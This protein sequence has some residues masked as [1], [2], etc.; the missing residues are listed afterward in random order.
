M[1][2]RALVAL[3]AMLAAGCGSWQVAQSG[4]RI[5]PAPYGEEFAMRVHVN[6]LKRLGGDVK[7]TEFR[8]YVAERLQREGLCPAGW[9]RQLCAKGD[10]CVERTNVAVTIFGRCLPP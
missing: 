3:A 8:V 10:D 2:K 4:Y 7:S 6:E 1:V 5:D 9:E